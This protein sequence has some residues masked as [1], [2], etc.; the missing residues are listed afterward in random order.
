MH[1]DKKPPVLLRCPSS[2]VKETDQSGLN[3]DWEEPVF[4]DNCGSLCINISSNI[5][6]GSRISVASSPFIVRY[7]A[8]DPAGNMNKECSFQIMIKKKNKGKDCRR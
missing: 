6:S 2:I 5:P 4:Q 8:R 3:V 7:E 1:L